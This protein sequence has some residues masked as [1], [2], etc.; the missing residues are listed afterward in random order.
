MDYNE[1]EGKSTEY[2][3][4]ELLNSVVKTEKEIE[5]EEKTQKKS[6]SELKIYVLKSLDC[7]PLDIHDEIKKIFTSE[8]TGSY[9]KSFIDKHRFEVTELNENTYNLKIYTPEFKKS[10][11]FIIFVKDSYW[12]VWT[13]VRK[14]W[15]EKT[16]EKFVDYFP[17]LEKSY[18]NPEKLEEITSVDLGDEMEGRSSF[19]GFVAKYKPYHE[20]KQ[21]SINMYGG[22]QEDLDTMKEEFHVEPS[23]ITISMKNSP[24]NCVLSHFH[25]DEGY[26]SISTIREDYFDWGKRM[27]DKGSG[28]FEDSDKEIFEILNKPIGM[29]YESDDLSFTEFDGFQSFILRPTIMDGNNGFSLN[30]IYDKTIEWFLNNKQGFYGYKWDDDSYHIIKKDT[31]DMIQISKEDDYLTV[32]PFD[33]CS[34]KTIK[35]ICRDIIEKVAGNITINKHSCPLIGG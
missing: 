16:L 12:H 20:E 29:S 21:I 19:S 35:Q 28:L 18:I 33:D 24:Q 3:R 23:Q 7:N 14:Y 15:A 11:Q 34:E 25:G 30:D 27:A 26:I 10:D 22:D 31:M 17:K 5:E 1:W 4:D 2:I 8:N 32:Y 9:A 13:L 6:R